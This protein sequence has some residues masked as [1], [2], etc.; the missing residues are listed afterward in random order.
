MSDPKLLTLTWGDFDRAVLRLMVALASRQ[1]PLDGVYG[2]PRG[3]LAL[4][5]ALSHRAALPLLGAPPAQGDFLWVDDVID[6]GE[7]YLADRALYPGMVPCAWAT[8]RPDLPVLAADI[9]PADSWLVFPWEDAGR[10]AEECAAYRES[11]CSIP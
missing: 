2:V 6:S 9:F 3:G 1:G 11:R 7:T 4:A 8:K 5:V 10:A